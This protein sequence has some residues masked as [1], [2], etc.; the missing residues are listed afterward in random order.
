MAALITFL[1][2]LGGCSSQSFATKTMRKAEQAPASFTTKPGVEFGKTGCRSPLLDPTDGTEIILVE[3]IEGLGD[4][5][6]PSGKYGM[7][8]NELLRID[9]QSGKV[10]GIVKN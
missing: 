6:V 7:K 8:N 1:V 2:V 3:S 4:Y 10:L 5:R 9:C